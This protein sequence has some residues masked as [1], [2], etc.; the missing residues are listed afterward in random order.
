M[1]F[2]NPVHDARARQA[3]VQNSGAF[4][5]FIGGANQYAAA[6]GLRVGY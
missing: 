6:K 4:G 2:N 5:D 3:E 1:G